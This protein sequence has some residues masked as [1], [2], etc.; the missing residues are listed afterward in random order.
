MANFVGET[1]F[2]E[3]VVERRRKGKTLVRLRGNLLIDAG[4]S[5]LDAGSR[6][7]VGVRREN[8][9]IGQGKEKGMNSLIGQVV[10]MAFL[11]KLVR[12]RVEL[13]NGDLIEVKQ[14]TRMGK[15]FEEKERV[16]VL[17][18]PEKVLI[19]PYPKNLLYEL[20]LK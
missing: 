5:D 20:A 15:I 8:M 16:Y 3:G 4:K 19:Y 9:S 17:F 18:P 10:R 7:V 14:P 1:N 12:Y 2:L 6:V 11:G 13:E